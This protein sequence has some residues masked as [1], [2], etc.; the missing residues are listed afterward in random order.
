[1]SATLRNLRDI[2]SGERS[3]EWATACEEYDVYSSGTLTADG[4]L[5]ACN[6]V[7][8]NLD[9][10][11]ANELVESVGS[12]GAIAWETLTPPAEPT[13]SSPARAMSYGRALVTNIWAETE[14]SSEPDDEIARAHASTVAAL[15]A[16]LKRE[17]ERELAAL[18]A[19]NARELEEV[20]AASK[21]EAASAS[22][23]SSAVEDDEVEAVRLMEL[24]VMEEHRAKVA[25][26]QRR[27]TSELPR[28][29]ER[30]QE[31]ERYWTNELAQTKTR[32]EALHARRQREAAARLREREQ[33]SR[34]A[35]YGDTPRQR[36]PVPPFVQAPTSTRV[37]V[38][39][40][41]IM[42][43]VLP[44]GAV[45]R[46]G[47]ALTTP[48]LCSLRAGTLVEVLDRARHHGDVDRLR[49]DALDATGVRTGESGWIS[50][51]L[52]KPR[53]GGERGWIVERVVGF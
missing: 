33:L 49:V 46:A 40:R 41:E 51:R 42:R 36:T 2:A 34:R 24:H 23:A 28:A 39:G 44:A 16:Y 7:G 6:Q 53:A 31:R 37:R 12:G 15:A 9:E 20:I 48:L 45:V 50:E 17:S 27:F 38:S 35:A 19:A 25:Q 52:R 14:A 30:L 1:M 29:A 13:M 4:L 26:L 3:A 5:L 32:L 18:R 22:A 21:A 47:A 10:R 43:V 11:C 8:V